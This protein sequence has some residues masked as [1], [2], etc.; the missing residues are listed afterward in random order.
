MCVKARSILYAVVFLFT[1]QVSS[2]GTFT[3]IVH[4][5]GND[6]KPGDAKVVVKAQNSL[7]AERSLLG[8]IDLSYSKAAVVCKDKGFK[9]LLI[10]KK[11]K[12]VECK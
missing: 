11:K 5:K 9:G 7:Q 12:I 3:C 2:A 4:C 1:A 10:Q 8:V 6:G